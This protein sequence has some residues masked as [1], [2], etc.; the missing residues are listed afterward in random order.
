LSHF[1]STLN[2]S[3]QEAC[4]EGLLVLYHGQAFYN[5]FVATW[6]ELIAD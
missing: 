5:A 1:L 6:P 2:I 4:M 3:S